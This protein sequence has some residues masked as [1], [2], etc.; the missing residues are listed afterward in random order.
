MADVRRYHIIVPIIGALFMLW[1]VGLSVDA[2]SRYATAVFTLMA[3]M[4]DAG[5]ASVILF[6]VA[7]CAVAGFLAPGK[8]WRIGLIIPQQLVLT[9][10]AVGVINAMYLSQFAD[11]V[12]RSRWF[13]INDQGA[14]VMLFI[15]HTV[16]LLLMTRNR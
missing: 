16:A 11:G 7:E 9:L 4:G 12:I 15:G 14:I 10:S 6:L 5:R 1:A 2:S 8:T 13:L 3:I